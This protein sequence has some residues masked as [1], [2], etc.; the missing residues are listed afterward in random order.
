MSRLRGAAYL[1]VL[2]LFLQACSHLKYASL[3]SLSGDLSPEEVALARTE[4]QKLLLLL[5]NT[6]DD[7][8]TF[9]GVGKIK[10]WPNQNS[11][12]TERVAWAGVEPCSLS[13]VMI[14]SGIPGPRLSTDCKYLYYLD[15]QNK[16][17]PFKKIRNVDT[18]L[19]KILSVPIKSKDII[20]LLRGRIPL[21]ENTSAALIPEL[22]GNSSVLVLGK[23]WLGVIEKIYLEADKK[24]VRKVEVFNAKGGL[25]YRAEFKSMQEIQGYRVPLRLEVSNDKGQG[26]SLEIDR[27]LANVSVSPSVFVPQPPTS[28]GRKPA[29]H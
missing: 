2:V 17:Q 5:N 20:E 14:I 6:N 22:S 16:K 4:A 12:I 1:V 8:N 10:L 27:Y 24:S 25:K 11:Q 21:Y 29:E 28:C 15:P 19:E 26:F 3:E 13:I 23:R 7:L 18:G 9:K